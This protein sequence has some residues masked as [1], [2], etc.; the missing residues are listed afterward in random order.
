MITSGARANNELGKVI[1]R[2]RK[3]ESC[4]FH[5]IHRFAVDFSSRTNGGLTCGDA[6]QERMFD[7]CDAGQTFAVR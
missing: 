2:F 4:V 5:S 7:E 1:H 3:H 6:L